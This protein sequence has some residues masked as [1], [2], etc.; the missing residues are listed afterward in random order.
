MRRYIF[1][2]ISGLLGIA[3]LLSLGFWQLRRLEWKEA[4]L[5]DIG[6]RI[7]AVPA[8]LPATFEP[9][10][11]Y[12]PVTVEGQTTGDE[13]LILSGTRDLG[14]GYEV[15]SSFETTD[16]RRI[17]VERGFI[18]QDDRHLPRPATT[19]KLVGNLHWPEEKSSSTP[20]P[21]LAENI[22]FAREVPR[23][24][25]HLGTEPMLVVAAEV[26]GDNQGVLPTPITIQ[27][28]PNS[29]LQYAVT[30]FM[31]AA[32]WAGMTVGLIWRIRQRKF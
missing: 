28:I 11:K 14:G 1:P 13:I 9:D 29:H 6:A 20:E 23:M 31:L 22:W 27:G 19:L 2:V 3:I 8:P 4:M 30:W 24:A 17:L 25:E 16:G 21:N 26:Q 10:M 5:S 12:D 7:H 15:I 18:T 32:V